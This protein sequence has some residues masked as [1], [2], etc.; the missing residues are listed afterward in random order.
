MVDKPPPEPPSRPRDHA[1]RNGLLV[2]THALGLF[3]AIVGGFIALIAALLGMIEWIS[4]EA[5]GYA[6][7]DVLVWFLIGIALALVGGFLAR[8]REPH[9]PVD[10]PDSWTSR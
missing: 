3:M 2:G 7:G 10:R 1:L 8:I 6:V 9:G 4:D 5:E